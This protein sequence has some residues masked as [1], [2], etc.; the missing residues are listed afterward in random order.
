MLLYLQQSELLLVLTC[1]LK[2]IV[3]SLL[4]TLILLKLPVRK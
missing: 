2:N 3:F 1:L 4:Y